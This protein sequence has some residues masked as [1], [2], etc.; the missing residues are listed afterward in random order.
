MEQDGAGSLDE[1]H[2]QIA[3]ATLGDAAK[4]RAVTGGHLLWHQAEPCGKVASVS[5]GGS[6]ANGSYRRAGDDWADT[7]NSHQL[8]TTYVSLCQVFDFISYPVDPLIEIV[9]VG[10]EVPGD[11][12]HVWR[13][14]ISAS[15][16]DLRQ[17][18][19]QE[20]M[21][22]SHSNAMLQKEAAKLIDHSCP[23]ANQARTHAMQCLQVELIV[24]FNRYARCR[25]A[26]NGFRNRV[27]VS[28]VVLVA[29]SK[30]LSISRR[31]LFD[32]VTKRN[33]FAG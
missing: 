17:L 15:S 18:P 26:L 23:I 12:D 14:H 5:K 8:R 20:A 6:I 24:S 1:Q 7:R 33:Q 9:P 10:N 31:N 13:K 11:P 21:S 30:R 28:E 25:R 29:L 3:V 16:Q 27:G 32:F 4:N 2:A 19:A 22:L